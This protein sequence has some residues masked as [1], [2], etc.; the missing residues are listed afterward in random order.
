MQTPITE[1]LVIGNE[2]LAGNVLDSNSH[3]LCQQVVAR[4]GQVRR[5]T[6]LRDEPGDIKDGLLSALGR[7]PELVL[8]CGGLGPTQDDLTVGA[9]GEALGRAVGQN[10]VAYEM[11]RDFYE[12]LHA[13]GE[14]TTPDMLPPR[15]KM[16]QMP[17]GAVPLQN[18][19]GAAPGVL[20]V[21]QG[22]TI[23]SLPGVPAEMKD[24]FANGLAPWLGSILAEQAYAERT[25]RTQVWDESILAPAVDLV[26]GHH[27]RVYVKSRAQVYGSGIADFVTVAARGKDEAEVHA[28]LDAAESDLRTELKLLG[29]ETE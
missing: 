3:W 13:R 2:V 16:A 28:L 11:I 22:I 12:G 9:I 29:I 14:V 18:R 23:V 6:V 4:G 5:I 27:P 26:A 1:I 7:R 15:A 10:A 17:E 8:T 25:I 20:L 21:H 24:I 19:V